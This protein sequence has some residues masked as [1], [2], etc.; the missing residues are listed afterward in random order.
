MAKSKLSAAEYAQQE[1]RYGI[2]PMLKGERLYSFSDTLWVAG[3]Y[4]IATW[5][6][7]QGGAM[8]SVQSFPQLILSTM[9]AAC[10]TVFLITVVAIFSCRYGI[11]HW[12]Y[13]RAVMGWTGAQVLLLVTLSTT[14]G[15]EAINAQ[16]Y[17][18]S[19]IQVANAAGASIG[20]GWA[21]WI[22][23]SC[24]FF[25]WVIAMRGAIAVKLATRIM[26]IA[27][28]IVGI[29]IAIII[30][31]KADLSALW[32]AQPSAPLEDN[33]SSYML[34]TEWMVAFTLSWFPV[35]GALARL[36][37][38][39]RGA[40]WGM[41]G[42]YGFLYAVF[43]VIGGAAAFVGINM[44]ADAS[45]NPT[46]Y[47]MKVGGTSLGLI[48]VI[49]IAIA[50]ITTQAVATYLMSVSTKI[51]N[52]RWSYKWIASFWCLLSAF[53]T[54]WGG[55]WDY[56]PRFLAVIGVISGPALA[57]V[58]SDFWIVRRGKFSMSGLYKK[59]VYKYTGGFNL[60]AVFSFGAGALSYFLL[61]DP[62]N[63][64]IRIPSLFNIF[65]ATG[66]SAIVTA[67]VYVGLAQVPALRRYVLH[68]RDL[69]GK[70]AEAAVE[71]TPAS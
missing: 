20:D 17:G 46:I 5:C 55:I 24:V 45:G 40:H 36:G 52:P 18:S 61:Y 23:L 66:F 38:T 43:I 9:G 8:A 50:N 42:G 14:W 60:V 32:N 13:L 4:G 28:V 21:K 53:L 44:G 16:M 63:Y 67:V 33:R 2:I 34:G 49:A 29:L 56:Y 58:A 31:V 6:Y 37:K 59:E 71:T 39:E 25:G 68:D 19:I 57:L 51:L 12:I 62:I 7:F 69:V 47:L 15:Y 1:T 70:P 35:I 64:V 26:G 65:T 11:D 10:G 54:A 27:L 41:W 48:S 3:A 30:L 22:G